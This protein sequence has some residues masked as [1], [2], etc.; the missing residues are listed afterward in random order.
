MVVPTRTIVHPCL[1][2]KVI[3][4]MNDIPI[5]FCSRTQACKDI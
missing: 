2:V 3:A 1:D 5:I 4:D